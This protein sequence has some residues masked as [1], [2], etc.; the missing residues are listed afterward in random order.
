MV[1]SMD[2]SLTIFKNGFIF[3]LLMDLKSIVLTA[4]VG[5]GSAVP[6]EAARI[7]K[8]EVYVDYPNIGHVTTFQR[9]TILSS[10]GDTLESIASQIVEKGI[11]GFESSSY[12]PEI[13]YEAVLRQLQR[14]YPVD[15]KTVLS[16]GTIL[17]YDKTIHVRKGF[18]LNL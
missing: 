3:L 10:R 11:S 6:A 4:T 17:K 2:W 7:T 15:P 18:H 1:S 9:Y 12:K 14:H 5:I 16:T 13:V 8:G